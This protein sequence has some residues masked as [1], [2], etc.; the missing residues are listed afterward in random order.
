[1]RGGQVWEVVQ[2]KNWDFLRIVS[3]NMRQTLL[4][5]ALQ[6]LVILLCCI[7]PALS[8]GKHNKRSD[9][10]YLSLPLRLN[11]SKDVW[12]T[13]LCHHTNNTLVHA[14]S[15]ITYL[16]LL[17]TKTWISFSAPTSLEH[18]KKLHSRATSVIGMNCRA[19][20]RVI[21]DI[22]RVYTNHCLHL[23]NLREILG[24]ASN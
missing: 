22:L 2:F 8:Q 18:W 17:Q 5:L 19:A 23:A 20:R 11:I 15:V 6:C 14:W 24:V 12:H 10:S 13:K 21:W 1:M 3:H 7:S 16:I 4:L 9:L